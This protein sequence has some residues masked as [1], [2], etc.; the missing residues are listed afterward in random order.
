[1]ESV[2]IVI[3]LTVLGIVCGQNYAGGGIPIRPPGG[4][5]CARVKCSWPQCPGGARPQTV[6]G[7]CC[8]SCPLPVGPDCSRTF[9][10]LDIKI[11]ADGRQA[12]V[13]PGECCPRCIDPPITGTKPGQCPQRRG[14][15]CR[16]VHPECNGDYSCPGSQKCCSTGC[17]RRCTTPLFVGQYRR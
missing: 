5:I 6:P 13:P 3:V 11:C 14:S 4:I 1:M 10:T 2:L 16:S 12:P 9:C 7:Q 15:A 8:P 17:G